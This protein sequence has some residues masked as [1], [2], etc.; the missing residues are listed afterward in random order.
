MTGTAVPEAPGTAPEGGPDLGVG[1]VERRTGKSLR[2]L[3]ARGTIINAGFLI[4]LQALGLIKGFVVA[5]FLSPSDYGVWG[6][7]VISLGTLLWLSQIGIDDKYLQQ[8]YPD[9]EEAFQV[10]FTLETL[11]CLFF[12]VILFIAVPLF[13]LAY[14][15]TKVIAPGLC[16]SL[17]LLAVP[18]QT[19]IWVFYRRM[20]YMKQRTLQALDP[21]TGFVVAVVLALA[22]F[23]YWS[24]VIGQV[25]GSWVAALAAWKASPYPLRFRRVGK[26]IREYV[27]FSWPLFLGSASGVLV[28]QVPIFFAQRFDGLTAVAAITLAG[29]ISVYAAHMDDVVTNTLY[30]AICAVKDR[31]DL[32]F[33]SFTKS[34]RMAVLWGMP[35]GI[36]IVLFTPDLVHYVIGD[37]WQFAV[38]LVQ[39]FGLIAGLNQIGF[40]WSA[41]Y[42][43]VGRTRPLAVAG[44]LMVVVTLS[45]AVPLLIS[46]GIKGFGVGM[47]IAT[48]VAVWIRVFFLTRLFPGF[49]VARHIVTALIPTAV[50]GVTVVL[51]RHV[52]GSLPGAAGAILEL[53][54]FLVVLVTT[55]FMTQRSLMREFLGYLGRAG[56]SPAPA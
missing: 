26:T 2:R 44:A 23:G 18:L 17:A 42:R 4:A 16:L 48:Y 5:S 6:L 10:A 45:V 52:D 21:L 39:I 15:T 50:A 56:S 9:Q 46:D 27:S 24:L 37:K 19:P 38:P 55:T 3:A 14:G 29:T 34:N 53:V 11:L 28:A 36:G 20:D 33:E 31:T 8:D 54:V 40:N 13:A 7:L 41:F 25:C 49:D 32:L 43:A 47:A 51:L 35:V 12:I 30:P 1:R 22:G